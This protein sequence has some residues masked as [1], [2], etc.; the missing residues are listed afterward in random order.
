VRYYSLV[1]SQLDGVA[2]WLQRYGSFWRDRFDEL[3]R[4]LGH[5][6]GAGS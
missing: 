2:E 6:R 3:H 5:E 4:Y 1:P